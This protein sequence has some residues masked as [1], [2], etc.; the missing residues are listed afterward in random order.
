MARTSF[1]CAPVIAWRGGT[2]P[3][4]ARSW[5]AGAWI[6]ERVARFSDVH[7]V[8]R[9]RRGNENLSRL[10]TT[11]HVNLELVVNPRPTVQAQFD[12]MRTHVG[13]VARNCGR[14]GLQRGN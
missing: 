5:R 8:S 11:K 12:R 3:R 2:S 6:G 1:S 7:Q 9:D 14:A 10:R 13:L 4:S